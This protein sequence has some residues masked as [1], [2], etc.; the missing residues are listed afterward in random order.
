MLDE[1]GDIPPFGWAIACVGRRP[2]QVGD[3]VQALVAWSASAWKRHFPL[4]SGYRVTVESPAGTAQG[5]RMSVQRGEFEAL[6]AIEHGLE[7]RVRGGESATP[8]VRMF[9][10]AQAHGVRHAQAL[11]PRLIARG[12]L[13]GGTVGLG[14]FLALAWLMIGV[15][16]PI[17]MLGGM[18]LMV[19]LMMA[20]MAGSSL[21]AWVGERL[22]AGHLDRA[23]RALERN[24][25]MHDDLRRWKAVS[26]QLAAQRAALV[27]HRRQ[28]FR[29]EPS[30][31][32]S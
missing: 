17:Y 30:V 23:I 9:G 11:G 27:G 15:N 4:E 8:A 3:D 2:T 21:G 20:L 13:F 7:P 19:A 22:A 28:P 12:R 26:R 18:L 24:V 29:S 5:V 1:R 16:N 25:A 10:R 31:L 14:L 6:V 32:A